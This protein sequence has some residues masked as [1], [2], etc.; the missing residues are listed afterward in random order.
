MRRAAFFVPP[1]FEEGVDPRNHNYMWIEV[2]RAHPCLGEYL[3]DR[4]EGIGAQQWHTLFQQQRVLVNDM[5]AQATDPIKS[6][7]RI[8]I[9]RIHMRHL[10][11]EDQ[12]VNIC[13]RDEH[14]LALHKPAGVPVHPGLGWHRGTVLNFLRH[15]FPINQY[16]DEEL[17]RMPVHRLDRATS[18]LLLLGLKEETQVFLRH[19]FAQGLVEKTYEAW[20]WG[21]PDKGEGVIDLAIGRCPTEPDRI[22]TDPAGTFGRPA[23]TRFRCMEHR[24]GLTRMRLYPQTGRTHQLRIHMAWLGHPIVG[25]LRYGGAEADTIKGLQSGGNRLYLHAYSLKFR[26]PLTRQEIELKCPS[27]LPF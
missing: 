3:R 7:D 18:G 10:L 24:A 17:R 5:A 14:L 2:D 9:R 25:D 21:K 12:A 22:I 4:T 15:L 19:Q 23:I 8:E 26:H 27:P 13:F 6:R 20:V 16:T 11:A 1:V